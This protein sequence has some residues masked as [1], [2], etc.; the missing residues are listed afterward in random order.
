MRTPNIFIAL[1][2]LVSAGTVEACRCVHQ[3]PSIAYRQASAVL[4]GTVQ[5]ARNVSQYDRTY[6]VDV[7]Q[8]WKRRLRGVVAVNSVRSSCLAD[9]QPGQKYL[10]YVVKDPAGIM[11]TSNCQ[12]TRPVAEAKPALDWLAHR[13]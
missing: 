1:A 3:T 2:A 9:L 12:G 10:I 6:Q 4:L 7:E 11:R 8:S 5:R 13:E